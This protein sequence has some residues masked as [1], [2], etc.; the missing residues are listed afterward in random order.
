MKLKN[1]II[2]KYKSK[3]KNGV[4]GIKSKPSSSSLPI[5]EMKENIAAIFSEVIAEQS[6]NLKKTP[7]KKV[8]TMRYHLTLARIAI[9]KK[10][11]SNKCCWECGQKESLVH[12]CWEC[13]LM[14]SL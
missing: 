11:G 12:C 4:T 7:F 3:D 2:W 6:Q 14:Q 10:T 1:K 13:K 5:R 8:T 9:M